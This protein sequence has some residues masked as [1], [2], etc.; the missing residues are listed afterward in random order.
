MNLLIRKY[1]DLDLD[2][3]LSSW[4]NASRLAHPFLTDQYFEHEKQIIPETHLPDADTWVAEI[5]HQVVGFVALIDNEVGAIFVQPEFHGKGVGRALMDKAQEL[6][7]DL[8]VEVFSRNLI[9]REAYSRYGFVMIAATT[10]GDTGHN[11]LRLRFS[12][13]KALTTEKVSATRP[14]CR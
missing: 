2:A 3:V 5:D 14:P 13:N 10:H 6:H 8:E 9:G 11:R 4:E 12:A 1:Q 7:A